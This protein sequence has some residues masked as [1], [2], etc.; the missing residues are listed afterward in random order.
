MYYSYIAEN[1]G[2]GEARNETKYAEQNKQI[3]RLQV[4]VHVRS[5]V[6]QQEMNFKKKKKRTKK[7]KQ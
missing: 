1:H 3:S 6:L 7:K 4:V 5:R 2:W